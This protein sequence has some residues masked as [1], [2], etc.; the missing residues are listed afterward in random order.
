MNIME[1]CFSD[2]FGGMEHY[3]RRSINWLRGHGHRVH[4]LVGRATPLADRLEA[5]GTPHQC[6]PRPSRTLPIYTASRVSRIIEQRGVDVVHIHTSRDLNLA[7]LAKTC[8]RLP[9]A[10]VYS[11]HL[12][13][14]NSKL[15]PVHRCIYGGVDLLVANSQSVLQDMKNNLPVSGARCELLY[16]GVAE[17]PRLDCPELRHRLG[18]S[19]HKFTVAVF[20]RIEHDKGQHV[21]VNAM[22][23]LL[24]QGVELQAFIAGP[25][26][27]Q[28][29]YAALQQ[30]IL[31]SG[32][33]S[34]VLTS[35]FINDTMVSM[36]CFDVVVLPTYNEAFG[37]VL[38]EAMNAGAAVIGA[39][40]GG[41]PE[42]IHHGHNGLLFEPGE[43]QELASLITSLLRDPHLRKRLVENGKQTVRKKFNEDEHYRRLT[44]LFDTP[45]C[46]Q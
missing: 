21:L 7:V 23:Q 10:L 2:G 9:V 43:A 27:D 40:V 26:M 35:G 8:C 20:G 24:T 6:L 38:I 4:A 14:R 19:D 12:R 5:D 31:A 29:Y 1:L 44:R 25:I 39:N 3:V 41:V 32:L 46:R 28:E 42:I 11:L 22:K 33:R 30:D 15:D 16:P 45:P 34:H 17:I 37:L 36:Q 18:L 13:P